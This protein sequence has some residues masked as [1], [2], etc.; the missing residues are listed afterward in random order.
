MIPSFPE[1]SKLNLEHREEITSFAN[2]FPPYHDFRFSNLFCWNVDGS[3]EIAQ[4]NGNLV[5]GLPDYVTGERVLTMLGHHHVDESLN[6]LLASSSPLKYVPESVIETIGEP[7]NFKVT[8][9]RDSFDYVYDLTDI[10]SLTGKQFKHKRNKINGA[11]KSLAQ[12]LTIK[13]TQSIDQKTTGDLRRLFRQWARN[14]AKTPQ[15]QR[16]ESIAFD[17]MLSHA[18]Y[19]DLLFSAIYVNDELAAFSINE[20]VGNRF[21]ICH[22]EKAL[23]HIHEEL[24]SLI[25]HQ[26]ALDLLAAGCTQVNWEPDLGIAGLR[27]SKMAFHPDHFLKKYLVQKAS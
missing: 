6:T 23:R 25:A 21:A 22:F 27:Q 12:N 15:E 17:H 18:D 1:F 19:F 26:A 24:P 8:E 2:Q 13:N 14:S 7:T 11:R 10:V 5:F 4:L 3:T 9:D 20:L 16:F